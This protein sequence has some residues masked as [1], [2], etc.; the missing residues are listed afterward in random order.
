[1]P[2]QMWT[3]TQADASFLID[4]SINAARGLGVA[5]TVVIVEGGGNT[6][7]LLRMDDAKLASIGV[8]KGKAWT[9]ALFQRASVDYNA[10]A[11]PG[12]SSY[13]L[14]NAYPGKVVPVTGRPTYLCRWNL[15]RRYWHQRGLGRTRR[16]SCQGGSRGTD[17]QG[18][19]VNAAA[20]R[21]GC[22][23]RDEG[24]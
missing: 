21:F 11:A 5:V 24:A 23:K 9:A 15:H 13:G 22:T 10:P 16:Q 19:R 20:L 3:L 8:A 4:H 6:V 1:M 18:C 2:R 14:L 12:G 17:E 7:G